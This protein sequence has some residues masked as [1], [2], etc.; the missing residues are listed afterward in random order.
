MNFGYIEIIE[1]YAWPKVLIS[2]WWK[3]IRLQKYGLLRN[4]IFPAAMN[5][6]KC[7]SGRKNI[8]AFWPYRNK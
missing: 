6:I 7:M 4:V 8:H 3:Y 5:R 2:S 1:E